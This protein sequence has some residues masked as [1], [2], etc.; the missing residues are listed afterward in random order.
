M[1][2]LPAVPAPP[3]PNLKVQ[4][5]LIL[6]QINKNSSLSLKML[7]TSASNRRIQYLVRVLNG[8]KP[9]IILNNVRAYVSKETVSIGNTIKELNEVQHPEYVPRNYCKV[10]P[11]VSLTIQVL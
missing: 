2:K 7:H 4:S 9:Q 5:P 1:T 3:K 10:N 8:T 11:T 6:S